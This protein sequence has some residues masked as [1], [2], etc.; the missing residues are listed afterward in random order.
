MLKHELPQNI[1]HVLDLTCEFPASLPR[2]EG[3][4]YLSFPVLDAMV[5]SGKELA[6]LTKL[7]RGLPTDGVLYVHCANGHGRT[8]LTAAMLVMLRESAFDAQAAFAQVKA[9][10]N[11]VGLSAAQKRS[12]QQA[13]ELLRAETTIQ[14]REAAGTH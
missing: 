4:N 9:R 14:T 1:T 11:G 2:R 13:A 10:R 12:L 8:G 6:D 7:L 3:I 5:P